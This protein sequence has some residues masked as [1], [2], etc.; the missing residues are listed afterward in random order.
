MRVF[1]TGGTGLVGGRLIERL[2]GRGDEVLILSRRPEAARAKWGGRGTIV[3]G[4]PT[5]R[6]D[7]MDAV[8]NCDAVVNLAG[9]GIFNQRWSA[10]VKDK[11][12][13]SRLRSTDNVV[14]ALAAQ[15]RTASGQPKV[16]VSASA[17]GYY[18]PH[19]DEELTEESPPGNDFLATLCADWERSARAA[20][21][22]GV[23]LAI[24]RI[25]VVLERGGGALAKMLTPFKMF[26]GGP[27]G[28]GRQYMS[29]IHNEDLVGLMLFALDRPDAEGVYNGTAPQPVT[30]RDFSTALGRVLHRPSF[31][32]APKF[33]LRIVLGEAANI[34]AEGQ[35]VVPRRALAQ[36]YSFRFPDVMAALRDLLG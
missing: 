24:V 7:W 32:P 13:T 35:R 36:G 26:V 4:D 12:R 20:T 22:H 10:A 11:L 30:N 2:L 5:E 19:G 1:V 16:L 31:M 15:P 21:A 28:S 18:G 9:E 23:R 29:W 3:P 33:A 25:G 17:I 27:V 6:G 8:R 14:A 34:V